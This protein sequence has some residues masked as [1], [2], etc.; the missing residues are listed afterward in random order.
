MSSL[1][2]YYV[3]YYDLHSCVLLAVT[4]KMTMMIM[5]MMMTFILFSPRCRLKVHRNRNNQSV[6]QWPF[7]LLVA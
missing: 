3:L 4:I 5:M 6:K 7:I 1:I 2:M